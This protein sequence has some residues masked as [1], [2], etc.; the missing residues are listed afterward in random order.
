MLSVSQPS[1]AV[2]RGGFLAGAALVWSFRGGVPTSRPLAAKEDKAK[3]ADLTSIQISDSVN[4]TPELVVLH[5]GD[6]THSAK[7]IKFDTLGQNLKASSPMIVPAG[8]LRH[9]LGVTNVSFT[10]GSS[11]LALAAPLG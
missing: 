4:D 6:L 9:V 11:R 5:T 7:A 2:D 1:V 8:K 3:A 10:A